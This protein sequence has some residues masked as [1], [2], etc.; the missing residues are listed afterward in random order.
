MKLLNHIRGAGMSHGALNFV[1]HR[2]IAGAFNELDGMSDCGEEEK[3]FGVK[4]AAGDLENDRSK[5]RQFASARFA[6]T[7]PT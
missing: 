5:V 2:A 3:M 4:P 7:R 6:P 1:S